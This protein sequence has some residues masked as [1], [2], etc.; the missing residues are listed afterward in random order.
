MN[1]VKHKKAASASGSPEI[2]LPATAE[3]I[4]AAKNGPAP[5]G[6]AEEVAPPMPASQPS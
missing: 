5:E 2:R 6:S 1:N 4:A 3:Q